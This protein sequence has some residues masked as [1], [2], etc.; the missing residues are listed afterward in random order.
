MRLRFDLRYGMERMPA[1][2]P[3]HY[4][5]ALREPVAAAVHQDGMFR[6]EVVRISDVAPSTAVH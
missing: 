5:V 3:S 2:M 4:S 1:L 6:R